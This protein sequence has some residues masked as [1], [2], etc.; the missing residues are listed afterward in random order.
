MEISENDAHWLVIVDALWENT[1][2][3]AVSLQERLGCKTGF[4]AY[5]L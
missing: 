4:E 1:C 2:V 5:N 3:V